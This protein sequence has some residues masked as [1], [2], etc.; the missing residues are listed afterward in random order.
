MKQ[1]TIIKLWDV[2]LYFLRSSGVFGGGLWG[3]WVMPH[4]AIFSSYETC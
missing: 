3:D 4:L 1:T 2:A